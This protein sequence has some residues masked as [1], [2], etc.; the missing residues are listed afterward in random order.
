MQCVFSRGGTKEGD[1]P[2]R[3]PRKKNVKE[4]NTAS[5]VYDA[6]LHFACFLFRL[7]HCL[8]FQWASKYFYDL[9]YIRWDAHILRMERNE[10]CAWH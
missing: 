8:P 2:N 7:S 9:S 6:F 3:R 1:M 10:I 5:S 4:N